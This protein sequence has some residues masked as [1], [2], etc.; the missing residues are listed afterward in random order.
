M[1][2]TPRPL[3]ALRLFPFFVPETEPSCDERGDEIYDS[4]SLDPTTPCLT[5]SWPST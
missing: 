5:R 3:H 2:G 1:I 4:E